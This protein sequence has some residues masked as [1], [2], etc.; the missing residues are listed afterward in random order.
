MEVFS[1]QKSPLNT[2]TA[3]DGLY[4]L[5]GRGMGWPGVHPFPISPLVVVISSNELDVINHL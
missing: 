1:P 4:L 5:D 3:V 2:K